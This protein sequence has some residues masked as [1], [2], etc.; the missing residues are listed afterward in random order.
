[1]RTIKLSA[2]AVI[3][4]GTLTALTVGVGAYV[5]YCKWGTSTVTYYINPANAD[6]SA[7]AAETAVQAGANAWGAQSGA[8]FRYSYAGRVNDTS[9]GYDNRNVVIFRNASNGGAIA[10]THYWMSNNRIIDADIIFWSGE[11]TFFTGTSGCSSGAYIE[12]IATHEFGHALGL[13]HSG[14]SGATMEASYSRCSTQ[15]RTLA[16]DDI[17]GI[18]SLYPPT[19][20]SPSPANTA[21]VVTISAPGNNASFAGGTNISFTGSARDNEDGTI[22]ARLVWTSSRD[23]QIGTGA[24]FSRTLTA[25][26]HSVKATATD[27][28]G[29]SSYS[30]ISVTVSATT[31]TNQVPTVSITSPINNT[32][33]APGT[34]LAFVASAA[35]A[36]DGNLTSKIAWSSSVSG[37]LGTGGSISRTLTAGTHKVRASVT[38][39]KGATATSY[40]TVVVS[41]S[42]TSGSWLTAKAIAKNLNLWTELRWSGL[43]ATTVDLYRDGVRIANINND[44]LHNDVVPKKASYTY[45]VC[46]ARTTICTNAALA[47]F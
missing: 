8:G 42:A 28:K 30:T 10:T 37:S 38:D 45:K 47:G 20:S 29:T 4:L 1:M 34:A 7:T 32:T 3:V 17:A 46:A 19:S 13:K 21:P 41:S 9:V 15:L 26:T 39:G 43:T 22:S 6:V 36:E 24:S 5:T 35:D 25:G 2:C 23:G 18:R 44:G 31:T 11:W 27:S 40:V 16:S 33:V 14:V 12:D